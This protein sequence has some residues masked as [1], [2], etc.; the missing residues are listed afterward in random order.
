[1]ADMQLTL[2]D[3]ER[4]FLAEFLDRSLKE[5][6]VEEHRTRT[7][8]FRELIVEKESLASSLLRKLGAPTT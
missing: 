8:S 4:Q 1:M 2:S 3:E 6:R 5:M 7:P